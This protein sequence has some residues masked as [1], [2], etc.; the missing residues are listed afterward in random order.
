MDPP[1]QGSDFSAADGEGVVIIAPYWSDN[2]I[3]LSGDV[4]YVQYTSTHQ[5]PAVG[6]KLEEA[7]EFISNETGTVFSGVCMLLVEWNNCPPFPA[8][9]SD[10][11]DPSINATFLSSVSIKCSNYASRRSRTRDTVKLTVCVSVCMCIP[12]VTAQRL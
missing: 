6:T 2:D 10:P 11:I 12:A 9:S 3:R 5:I 7:S 4:R 8:G 1:Q